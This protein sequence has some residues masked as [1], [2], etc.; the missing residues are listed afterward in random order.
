[1]PQATMPI[2][3]D[4]RMASAV[5]GRRSRFELRDQLRHWPVL[6]HE[7]LRTAGEI[8]Q[9][10]GGDIDAQPLVERGE[11]LAEMDR[12]S[13]GQLSP[14]GRGADHL[15]AFQAAAGNY[16]AAHAGPVIASRIGVDFGGAAEL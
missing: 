16:G 13:V 11:H 10:R 3:T 8:S 7:I 9:L 14:A 2:V 1:M 6:A 4:P 12:P 15:A 5:A